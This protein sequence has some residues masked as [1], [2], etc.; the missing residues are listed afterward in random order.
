MLI[1]VIDTIY[2]KNSRITYLE[3]KDSFKDLR[4][5]VDQKLSLRKHINEKISKAY[6]ML[7]IIKRNFKYLNSKLTCTSFLYKFLVHVSLA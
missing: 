7:D 2:R 6:A 1:K 4:I 5:I 3:Q